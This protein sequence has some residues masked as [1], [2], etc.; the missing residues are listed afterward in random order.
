MKTSGGQRK[1]PISDP[2]GNIQAARGFPFCCFVNGILFSVCG[3]KVISR[4]SFVD[5]NVRRK[6][7]FPRAQYGCGEVRSLGRK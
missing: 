6:R 3:K 1:F 7:R 4:G 5:H 2:L